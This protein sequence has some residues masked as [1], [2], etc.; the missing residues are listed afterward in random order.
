MWLLVSIILLYVQ[1]AECDKAV[2]MPTTKKLSD[3]D[4]LLMQ[5]SKF[6]KTKL[7][8]ANTVSYGTLNS[9]TIIKAAYMS[10]T[11]PQ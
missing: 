2:E 4:L 9:L 6:D 7:R 11:S 8:K 10:I 5:I 3:F 1:V